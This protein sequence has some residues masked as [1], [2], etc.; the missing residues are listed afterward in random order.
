MATRTRSRQGFTLVEL[1]VV[2]A[3]IAIL[4]ALLF[5]AIQAVREAARKNTCKSNLKNLGTALHN[6]AGDHN[7]R[8]PGSA[9]ATV[10]AMENNTPGNSDSTDL[11]DPT[12]G[13]WSWIVHLL[14][15]MEGRAI[16]DEMDLQEDVNHT[17]DAGQ[18][19]NNY[20]I[21]KPIPLLRCPTYQGSAFSEAQ[22]YQQFQSVMA[23][24]GG[25]TGPYITNY[26]ALG[27]TDVS[28]LF[29][30]SSDEEPN[31]VMYPKSK[32]GLSMSDGTSSTV[33]LTETREDVYAAWFDGVTGAVAGFIDRA[34]Q[35]QKVQNGYL[36]KNVSLGYQYEY[37]DEGQ[38]RPALNRGGGHQRA[39]RN[40]VKVYMASGQGHSGQGD[41]DPDDQGGQKWGPSS[42]HAAITHV[43]FGDTQVR[44]VTDQIDHAV[45]MWLI[46]RDGRE[47]IDVTTFD[48]QGQ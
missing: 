8:L 22:E 25:K 36:P 44:V 42:E 29:P 15:Y 37:P 2:I 48:R 45:W 32:T 7:E 43:L 41:N 13:V 12:R 40:K 34:E 28:R 19:G 31:G 47:S 4:I 24:T 30:Q 27:A 38:L 17:S 6:Y 23:A 35:G 18:E 11:S 14:P 46:T 3:I 21:L 9:D 16:Y 10:T 39:D 26:L 5:P 20:A 33:I 1:L